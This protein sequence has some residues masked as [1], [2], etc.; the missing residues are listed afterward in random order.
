MWNLLKGRCSYTATLEIEGDMVEFLPSGDA[1]ALVCGSQVRPQHAV[2]VW[3]EV[4]VK[5]R[6]P[7]C[8][9]LHSFTYFDAQGV[10]LQLVSST[11]Q[12]LTQALIPVLLLVH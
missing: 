4:V 2:H 12:C 3:A 11:H 5:V 1:Y 10:T 7:D 8:R 9:P 6:S